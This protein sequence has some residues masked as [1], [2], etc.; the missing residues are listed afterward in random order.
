MGHFDDGQIMLEL[1]DGRTWLII[2]TTHIGED[3]YAVLSPKDGDGDEFMYVRYTEDKGEPYVE[4]T[5]DDRIIAQI[6]AALLLKESGGSR[7]KAI[8]QLLR[9][10]F[11]RK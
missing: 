5:H 11:G 6:H 8:G 4:V 9:N 10:R 7:L 2:F 1:S 3:E